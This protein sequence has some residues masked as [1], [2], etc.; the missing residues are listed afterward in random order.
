HRMRKKLIAPIASIIFSYGCAGNDQKLYERMDNLQSQIVQER[1]YRQEMTREIYN[2]RED[3][4]LLVKRAK[5]ESVKSGSG[6]LDHLA[7]EQGRLYAEI[8]RESLDRQ[9]QDANIAQ[10][11]SKTEQSNEAYKR[12]TTRRLNELEKELLKAK[13]AP[14]DTMP[15]AMEIL[16]G[17]KIYLCRIAENS[18]GSDLSEF[19]SPK[20]YIT[21][22]S[23]R[24][25]IEEGYL[26]QNTLDLLAQAYKNSEGKTTAKA[27][28]AHSNLELKQSSL[29]YLIEERAIMSADGQRLQTFTTQGKETYLRVLDIEQKET[30]TPQKTNIPDNLRLEMQRVERDIKRARNLP[31]GPVR[32]SLLK[33]LQKRR[34]ELLRR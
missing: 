5:E 29:D 34:Q 17:K 22:E 1:G 25:A 19:A 7:T 15:D 9:R 6:R 3:V 20:A 24:K 21:I 16:K 30:S 2:M 33:N 12:Q 13:R 10:I 31:E 27:L 4:R 11:M 8:A 26:P 32:D 18:G 14:V 23:A 28:I